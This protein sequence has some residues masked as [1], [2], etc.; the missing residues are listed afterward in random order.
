[1]N[2]SVRKIAIPLLTTAVLI[3]STINCKDQREA[4][5]KHFAS[6]SSEVKKSESIQ[7][8][9]TP[10]APEKAEKIEKLQL[11]F[12]SIPLVSTDIPVELLNDNPTAWYNRWHS[13]TSARETLD[14]ASFI[15]APDIFGKAFLGLLL[16]KA[17]ENVKVRLLIDV[18]GSPELSVGYL[19][20]I[21]GVHPYLQALVNA[22]ITVGMF[23]PPYKSAENIKN[24]IDGLING[25]LKTTDIKFIEASDHDKIVIVDRSLNITGGRNVQN[26]YFFDP[27]D[28]AEAYRD[29]DVAFQSAELAA[30]LKTAIDD[31]FSR[32]VTTTL[33]THPSLISRGEASAEL[34]FCATAMDAWIRNQTPPAGNTDAEKKCVS[35]LATLTKMREF[36]S[37]I[38]FKENLVGKV[39]IFDKR[40]I[41]TGENTITQTLI[42]LI[43]AAEK[44]IIIQNPYFI[45]TE[46]AKK[47][48]QAANDRGVK[49]IV[50]TNSPTSGT[51]ALDCFLIQSVFL[52]DWKELLK[53]MPNMEIWALTG[54]RFLHA[55]VFVFDRT[56]TTI[57]TYNMDY[58]SEQI[59]S[60]VLALIL[61]NPFSVLVA[62]RILKVDI[63]ESKQYQIEVLHDGTIKEI[64]GPMDTIKDKKIQQLILEL[65]KTQSELIRPLI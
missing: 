51:C 8:Q 30:S 16:K 31:E 14:V 56:I 53:S 5:K 27:A 21:I 38:P 29:T 11:A 40:S 1:M 23:N 43:N 13:M 26:F 20:G 36:S 34:L 15:V 59:N 46:A 10:K 4:L 18:R 19:K 37:Y 64:Y 33:S 41:K 28:N 52:K 7:V 45:L 3:L 22:G 47:A 12:E 48:L 65:M 32:T 57:S 42:Q 44:E 17:K 63:A 25:V 55:K 9:E 35:E 39:K 54:Q 58:M 60:E 2:K 24:L 49:I 6:D 61:S 62:E 50:H